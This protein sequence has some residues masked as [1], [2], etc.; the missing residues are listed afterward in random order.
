[1]IGVDFGGTRIKAGLVQDGKV[2]SE[3]ACPTRGGAKA[4]LDAIAALVKQ[5]APQPQTVGVAIPGEIDDSGRCWRLPNVKGFAGVKIARELTKRLG[6]PVAVENDAT[7]AALAERRFGH[8]QRQRSFLLVTL[9]TGVGGGLCIDGAVRRGRHGF[10]GEIGHVL[11]D[12]TPNAWR[13]GCGVR[14]CMEAYTGTVGLLRKFKALGGKAREV[15]AVAAAAR[16]GKRAGVKTFQHYG[17]YLGLGLAS[18]QNTLDLDALVFTG[19]IAGSLDL[20]EPSLRKALKQRVF[21][22]PLAEVTI[23]RSEL[24]DHAGVIG[25]ALLPA[26]MVNE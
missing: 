2:V 16:A 26:I 10:A 5:L 9:G 15:A 21:A 18:I 6:C 14:G 13:C 24:G 4:I 12:G 20:I 3:V 8:G 22:P 17:H 1:M 19:G 25:A 11:V 7:A 23:L